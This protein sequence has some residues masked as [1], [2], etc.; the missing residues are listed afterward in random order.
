MSASEIIS[1]T[2]E[3]GMAKIGISIPL[4]LTEILKIRNLPMN[5]KHKNTFK[6]RYCV[7][8][9][10]STAFKTAAKQ[11]SQTLNHWTLS[12]HCTNER[13]QVCELKR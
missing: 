8:D 2:Y 9:Q 5:L 6:A 1:V 10:N 7:P 11:Q 3:T 12:Y 4:H 13:E